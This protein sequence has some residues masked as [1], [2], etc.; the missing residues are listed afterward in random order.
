VETLE[1]LVNATKVEMLL[2]VNVRDVQED[3]LEVLIPLPTV[4]SKDLIIVNLILRAAVTK[5]LSNST[6]TTAIN[7]KHVDQELNTMLLPT[8]VSQFK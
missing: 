4:F 5:D 1:P 6:K 2:L 7:A 3:I 8:H